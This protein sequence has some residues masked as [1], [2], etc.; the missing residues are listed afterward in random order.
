MLNA[1]LNAQTFDVYVTAPGADPSTATP[2]FTGVAYKHMAPDSGAD[3]LEVEADTY[4]LRIAPA[5]SKAV[6]FDGTVVVPKNGDLS[7]PTIRELT[8]RS[9]HDPIREPA[10]LV[11]V[12]ARASS[13]RDGA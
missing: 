6:I 10:D 8:P 5:G 1:A 4:R 11:V 9:V 7:E 3:S 2:R 13:V 12:L